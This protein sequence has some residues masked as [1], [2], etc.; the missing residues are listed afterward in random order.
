MMKAKN[1]YTT[2]EV[3]KLLEL[4]PMTILNAIKRGVL[5]AGQTHGG[6][7]RI[8]QESL[9]TYR[10]RFRITNGKA[11]PEKKRV[12]IVDDEP[13]QLRMFRRALEAD[14]GL[15]VE[16]TDSGYEAGFLTKSF[17]PDLILLD[18][19]LRDLDGRRVA[20][21]IRAD[22]ELKNTKIVAVTG[23]EDPKVI[24]EVKQTG[25]DDIIRKPVSLKE[26]RER[27]NE[28]LSSEK[29][30]KRRRK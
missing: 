23:A 9:D 10:K 11:G 15:E 26:L 18:I 29:G 25:V 19:Y 5:R 4:S 1:L 8:S 14:P 2:G 24:E 17:K 30:G 6:H 22:D 21:Q 12:L 3:A 7:Y 13:A 28:I 27:V 16:A 20:R